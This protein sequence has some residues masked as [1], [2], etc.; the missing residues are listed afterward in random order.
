MRHALSLQATHLIT[1]RGITAGFVL[2]LKFV[3]VPGRLPGPA[4]INLASRTTESSME[5][6]EAATWLFENAKPTDLLATDLTLSPFVAATT[7]LP[8]DVSPI[9]YR[10][11][12]GTRDMRA[13][14]VENENGVWEFINLPT[15]ITP[16][17]LCKSGVDWLWVD[18]NRTE[19]RSWE[20]LAQV[21]LQNFSVIVLETSSKPCASEK[22]H[23]RA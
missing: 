21:A 13:K 18:G 14:I 12:Y 15:R 7:H 22:Q 19:R 16:K 20:N 10:Y 17:T 8:T 11:D 2:R 5:Q 6:T 23:T 1:G 3:S 4:P 9:Q